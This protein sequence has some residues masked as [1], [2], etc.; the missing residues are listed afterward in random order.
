MFLGLFSRAKC[1]HKRLTVNNDYVS[2]YTASSRIF[3]PRY[4]GQCIWT[5]NQR[6]TLKDEGQYSGVHIQCSQL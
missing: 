4:L 3:N 6:K 5:S 2:I 1:G